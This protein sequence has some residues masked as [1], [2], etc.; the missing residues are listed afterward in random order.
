[1]AEESLSKN[2]P[3]LSGG[4]SQGLRSVVSLVLFIH[5]FCVFAALSSNYYPS[6]L[7]REFLARLR[8]YTQLFNFDL[9]VPYNLTMAEPVDSNHRVEVLPTGADETDANAWLALPDVGLK[10]GE[11]RQ[12]YERLGELMD[13]YI[14]Q[15][16]EDPLALV[17]AS[18]GE[19][20]LH[21]RQVTPKQIRCR[22]H[23]LV[24]PDLFTVPNPEPP[25]DP[26]A[27]S[28]FSVVY[29]ADAVVDDEAG[30][31][32]V[33]KKEAIGEVAGATGSSGPTANPGPPGPAL[34]ANP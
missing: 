12:R 22:R 32:Q 11:R 20:F 17:T 14:G 24:H 4:P 13:T 34:P 26:S 2:T 1:M 10:G 31:V 3:D 18:V 16:R 5:L 29:A 8:I 30:T 25:R 33:V 9:F 15:Q 23:S 6:D 19:H 27:S 21:Q 7:Q 28:E